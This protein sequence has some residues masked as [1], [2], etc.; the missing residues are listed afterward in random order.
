MPTIS[1]RVHVTLHHPHRPRTSSFI[2]FLVF[3]FS[4]ELKN[5][6]DFLRTS[7]KTLAISSIC[8][9]GSFFK[10]D[11]TLALITFYIFSQ[12]FATDLIKVKISVE[13]FFSRRFLKCF[14]ARKVWKPGRKYGRPRSSYAIEAVDISRSQCSTEVDWSIDRTT[15]RL[16]HWPNDRP[17]E[18]LTNRPSNRSSDWP[19]D[20]ATEL[21]LPR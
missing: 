16:S 20:W 7:T 2:E 5:L 19:I 15:E 10:P 1:Q 9:V 4:P 6:E 12:S 17:A 18:W 13:V 8:W 14:S 3:F 11:L 21:S